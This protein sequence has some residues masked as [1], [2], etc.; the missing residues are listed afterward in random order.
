VLSPN[1]S[2]ATG[3]S[4]RPTGLMTLGLTIADLEGGAITPPFAP[5]ADP[6][7][8]PPILPLF[9]GPAANALVA[10]I[11]PATIET[12]LIFFCSVI[13]FSLFQFRC[14]VVRFVCVCILYCFKF[15][16]ESDGLP[17][18]LTAFPKDHSQKEEFCGRII[19]LDSYGVKNGHFGWEKATD[20]T[21]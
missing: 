9:R 4:L 16:L 19:K 13:S 1:L 18:G 15:T 14:F 5:P 20:F 6:P 11:I 3:R 2:G 8:L 10:M 17:L 21:F 7:I 12:D